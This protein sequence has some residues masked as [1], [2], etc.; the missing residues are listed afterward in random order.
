MSPNRA[1]D[2]YQS[3]ALLS[4]NVDIKSRWVRSTVLGAF[5]PRSPLGRL[6]QEVASSEENDCWRIWPKSKCIAMILVNPLI[7]RA[8]D[9]RSEI[10]NWW[11]E[12]S[13]WSTCTKPWPTSL[14][15]SLWNDR[16]V[17]SGRR[18]EPSHQGAQIQIC[19]SRSSEISSKQNPV[20]G[21]ASCQIRTS[22]YSRRHYALLMQ[23][24]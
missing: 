15:L 7:R 20:W 12:I 10:L 9:V 22:T 16:G 5:R 18:F 14:D 17:E 21:F 13:S 3:K 23:D 11:C 24:N 4:I 19:D 8:V 6:L 1:F 2:G